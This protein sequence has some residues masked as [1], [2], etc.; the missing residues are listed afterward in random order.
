MERRGGLALLGAVA[1]ALSGCGFI[2][3]DDGAAAAAATAFRAALQ[4]SDGTAACRLLAPQTVHEV[5]QSAGKPCPAAVVEDGVAGQGDPVQVDVYGQN[6]RV[7][8]ADDVVFLANF[9]VGWRL[10]AA[11]CTPQGDRP[12]DCQ[13]KGS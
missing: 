10:T 12:Y 6:A 11:G 2:A 5:A 9:P 3:P 1:F 4:R 13:V 8:F 7:V